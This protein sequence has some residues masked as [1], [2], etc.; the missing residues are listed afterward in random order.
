MATQE[1]EEK[2]TVDDSGS[3]SANISPERYRLV[4]SHRHD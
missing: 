3:A 1:A 2:T 4:K